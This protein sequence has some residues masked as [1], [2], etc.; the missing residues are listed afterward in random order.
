MTLISASG[1]SLITVCRLRSGAVKSVIEVNSSGEKD[2]SKYLIEG[3]KNMFNNP[4][5][6]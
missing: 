3:E 4:P 2:R 6:I 5:L 1:A